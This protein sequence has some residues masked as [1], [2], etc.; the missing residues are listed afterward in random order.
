MLRPLHAESA[1]RRCAGESMV[2]RRVASLSMLPPPAHAARRRARCPVGQRIGR[3]N[4][5]GVAR[6]R[7]VERLDRMGRI[8]ALDAPLPLQDAA[9]PHSHQHHARSTPGQLFGG[10]A[11][12][13]ATGQG[14]RFVA[15]STRWSTNP[16]GRRPVPWPV[17]C[18]AAPIRD[19]RWPGAS[20]APLHAAAIRVG[21]PTCAH[22]PRPARRRCRSHTV[23]WPPGWY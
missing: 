6:C 23:R 10:V 11:D 2:A 3:H 19:W 5:E 21:T 9:F 18:S 7:G 22:R 4:E 13:G 17:R 15:L 16:A 20:H 8:L 12:V 14:G 1:T